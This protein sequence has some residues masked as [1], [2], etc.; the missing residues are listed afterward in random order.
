MQLDVFPT[1]IGQ[2]D[3]TSLHAFDAQGR[4]GAF[5]VLPKLGQFGEIQRCAPASMKNG[6]ILLIG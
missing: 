6:D 4:E 3:L 2:C 1:G 5:N